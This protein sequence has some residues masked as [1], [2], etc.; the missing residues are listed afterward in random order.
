MYKPQ[1]IYGELLTSSNYTAGEKKIVGGKNGFGVKLI[2]IYSTWGKV[3]TVDHRRG[4]KYSQEFTDNLSTI[5]KPK[6]TKVKGKPYTK[7]QF[8]LDFERFGIKGI[9]EDIVDLFRKRAYDMAAV[10]DKSVKVRFNNEMIPVR[11]MEDYISLYIGKNKV[12][13]NERFPS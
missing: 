2:Y 4:L 7:I 10:T 13:N 12:E 9:T 6:I 1:L 3:E 5:K 8:E 11:S